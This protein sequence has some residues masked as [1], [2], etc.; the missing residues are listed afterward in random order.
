M[1][2]MGGTGSGDDDRPRKANA[3]E[4]GQ[5][6][7]PLSIDEIDRRIAALH[8]E[9]ERLQAVRAGKQASKAAAD[10]FFKR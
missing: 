10:L 6:L 8:G 7:S 9:I 5:D 1:T 3:H 2:A 4:I